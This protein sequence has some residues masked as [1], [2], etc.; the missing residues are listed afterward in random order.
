MNQNVRPWPALWALCIGFFMILVDTTIVAIA[1]P[2]ILAAFDA[3]LTTVIWV[4]SAYLLAYAVPLLV[5]GR[6][7]DRFG[8]KRVYLVGLV[9]FTLASLACGLADSIG[10]LIAA[11]AVQGFGAALMTPQTMAIIAR[12]FPPRGRG[13]AMARGEQSEGWRRSSVRSSAACSPTLWVGSGSS[14]STFRSASSP[15]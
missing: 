6:L 10:M 8:P 2:V 9:V 11:R 14:S 1:N 13:Q 12:V 3:D 4:T 7:G 5:T 15:S